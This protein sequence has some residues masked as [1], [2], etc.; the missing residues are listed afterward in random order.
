MG[1]FYLQSQEGFCVKRK[2]KP[3][4]AATSR[5]LEGF[6]TA[7][8]FEMMETSLQSGSQKQL[9]LTGRE[10]SGAAKEF[11]CHGPLLKGRRRR[12]GLG[13]VRGTQKSGIQTPPGERRA[14]RGL[15]GHTPGTQGAAGPGTHSLFL[16]KNR[17]ATGSSSGTSRVVPDRS[18]RANL[19]AGTKTTLPSDG[20]CQGCRASRPAAAEPCWH[21]WKARQEQHRQRLC[22]QRAGISAG[23]HSRFP[24]HALCSGSPASLPGGRTPQGWPEPRPASCLTH[25]DLQLRAKPLKFHPELFCLLADEFPP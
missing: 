8:A 12:S 21:S 7:P 10:K 17:D 19:A 11:R 24:A 5:A 20:K 6:G 15:G 18:S 22:G 23:I 25:V 3:L 16:P 14:R 13:S 4:E 1:L 9:E 2:S